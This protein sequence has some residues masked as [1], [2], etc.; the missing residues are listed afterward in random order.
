VTE[1]QRA[2]MQAALEALI[3]GKNVRAGE[4][5]TKHQPT[6]EDVAIE[7]LRAALAEQ[8]AEHD[9]VAGRQNENV[10]AG[11][12]RVAILKMAREAGL[13]LTASYGE[14]PALVRF[15]NLVAIRAR[16]DW[17][18]LTDEERLD[19]ISVAKGIGGKVRT[20][21]HLLELVSA[22]EAALKEKNHD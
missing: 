13:S 10:G 8:D 14:R 18:S 3:N 4:C 9:P 1:Q 11:M 21:S 6:M 22:A 20:D 7:Q 17:Q 12:T 16:R 19:L 15:A 2:T 5:G